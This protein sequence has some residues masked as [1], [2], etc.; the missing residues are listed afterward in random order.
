MGYLFFSEVGD[1]E[2]NCLCLDVGQLFLSEVRDLRGDFHFTGV[3]DLAFLGV[4]SLLSLGI[5]IPEPIIVII[6]TGT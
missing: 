6:N 1:L 4:S 5:D 2:G 3:V